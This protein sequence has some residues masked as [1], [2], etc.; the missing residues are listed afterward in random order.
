MS[1]SF[2][3]YSLQFPNLLN[4]VCESQV[5]FTV[6]LSLM[7]MCSWA[8]FRHLFSL[9]PLSSRYLSCLVVLFEIINEAYDH[10][11]N[12]CVFLFTW[13]V[14]TWNVFYKT[15]GFGGGHT[16]FT[17]C[18]GVATTP[19]SINYRVVLTVPGVEKLSLMFLRQAFSFAWT[20]QIRLVGQLV[21]GACLLYHPS[22]G[23]PSMWVAT[24][25]IMR[26]REA[27]Y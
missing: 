1:A 5:V 24:Q 7:F 12:F 18:I 20:T 13:A 14:L 23:V 19:V 10:S 25:V 3:L 11:P 26:R 16:F 15:G 8:S 6:P 2:Q 27:P 21:L 4:M 22:A 9:S 17:V